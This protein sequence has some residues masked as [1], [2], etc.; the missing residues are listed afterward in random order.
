MSC[1]NWRPHKNNNCWD[2]SGNAVENQVR[3][4]YVSQHQMGV[5]N[6]NTKISNDY[7][8]FELKWFICD[9]ITLRCNSLKSCEVQQNCH[10]LSWAYF[11]SCSVLVLTIKRNYQVG[12][13]LTLF[14]QNSIQDF[15]STIVQLFVKTIIEVY[16]GTECKESIE[17]K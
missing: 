1:T 14:L 4:V 8:F 6:F 3:L 5:L 2:R 10:I 15:F 7:E 17:R 16:N 11:I 12:H 13:D 9:N